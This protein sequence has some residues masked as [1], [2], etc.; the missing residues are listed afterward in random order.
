VAV[1]AALRW[2]LPL[3]AALVAGFW[4]RGHAPFVAWE[5]ARDHGH[6]FSRRPPPAKVWTGEPGIVSAWFEDRGARLPDVPDRVGDLALVGARFCPLP[7]VSFAPH[8][9]YASAA[10][11]VSVFV[12]PH[13]VRMGGRFAGEA[14]HRAVRLLRVGGE[15]VG[16]VGE[17]E[18]DVQAFETSFR[19]ALAAWLASRPV[20][21]GPPR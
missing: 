3:A 11:H 8:L 21:P 15:V 14:G 9:Y 5:L 19:P 17:R 18:S 2:A 16:I 4:L 7:D 20:L 6:C 1:P 13:R 10:S 12:V